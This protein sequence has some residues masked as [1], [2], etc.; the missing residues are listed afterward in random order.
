VVDCINGG[1]IDTVNDTC[2]LCDGSGEVEFE[3]EEE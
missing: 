3:E 2:E 1:F